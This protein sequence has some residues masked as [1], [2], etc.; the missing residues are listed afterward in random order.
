MYNVGTVSKHLNRVTGFDTPAEKRWKIGR[1]DSTAASGAWAQIPSHVGSDSQSRGLRLPVTWAQAPSHV[2]S[3]SQSRDGCWAAFSPGGWTG[4]A[5]FQGR[6]V[7][8][9][10]CFLAATWLQ[11]GAFAEGQPE[12]THR[13]CCMGVSNQGRKESLL[14][15]KIM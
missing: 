15:Q 2:G 4:R 9:S 10:I 5:C 12:A 14:R 7:A 3:G 6:G 13:P 8:E 11:A 1:Q